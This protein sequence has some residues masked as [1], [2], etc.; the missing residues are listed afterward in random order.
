LQAELAYDGVKTA[1]REWQGVAVG[2]YRQE[3]RVVQ[4]ITRTLEHGG[5]NVSA[6]HEARGA[7]DRQCNES[8]LTRSRGDIENSASGCYLG[9]GEHCWYKKSGPSAYVLVVG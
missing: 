9:S 3:Q 4:A 1:V 7:D 6:N 5:R 2:G 8:S